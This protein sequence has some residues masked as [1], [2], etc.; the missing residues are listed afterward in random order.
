MKTTF[1]HLT[2][3]AVL[4]TAGL[5]A[6]AGAL[7][8]SIVVASTTSTEQSGLFSFLLPEFKKARSSWTGSPA[9][10]ARRPSPA[11]RSAASS[12]SSR[13]RRSEA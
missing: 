3:T 1:R 10:P 13:T 4:G 11:T 2:L 9:R 8:Q 6:S 12:C 7:A 5:L